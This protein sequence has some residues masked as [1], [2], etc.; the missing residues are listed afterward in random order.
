[1]RLVNFAAHRFSEGRGLTIHIGHEARLWNGDSNVFQWHTQGP[2]FSGTII[3]CALMALERWLYEQIDRGED[4]APWIDRILRESQSLAFA[5]LLFDVGKR[6]PSL[7]ADSLKP[8]LGNWLLVDWDRQVVT[9]HQPRGPEPAGFWGFQPPAMI[10]LGRDWYGMP[11]RRHLLIYI[12]G[13]IVDT[14]IADETQWPFL[15]QLR[16]QWASELDAEADQE[17]P[18]TLLWLIERFNPGNYTFEER[19]GKRVAVA[20]DWPAAMVQ[21]T[22]EDLQRISTGQMVTSFPF[23]CRR[24]LDS[25]QLLSNEQLPQFWDFVQGIENLSP[26]LAHDGEPLQHMEDLLCGA[27][28]VLVVK[29]YDW[30][31]SDAGRI[32]WCRGKLEEIVRRP[33]AP[34]PFDSETAHGDQ[35]WDSFAA[36]AG[37]ALLARDREDLL[38]RRLVANGVLSF[39]YS[40]TS[41]TLIR[42]CQSRERLGDEFD[43]MLSLAVRSSGLRT[44]HAFARRIKP[45]PEVEEVNSGKAPLTE[46]FIDRR[47]PIELPDIH[48]LDT[49]AAADIEAVRARQFPHSERLR[50]SETSSQRPGSEMETLYRDRLSLDTRLLSAT[51]AWLDLGSAQPEERVKWIG[52]VRMFLDLVLSMMPKITDARRQRTDDHPDEFD[53]WVFGRV[54]EAIPCLT[55]AEDHRTL[56]R[57]ILDLGPPSHQWIERF[58]WEWFTLG[59]RAAQNPEQFAAIWGDMIEYALQS[60]AWD[61]ATHRSH[62]LDDAVFW[63]LG[64]GTKINKIGQRT[65]YAAALASMEPLFA[66]AV[67]RWFK[68]SKLVSGFLYWVMQPAAS[69]LLVP[70]II[71][72]APVIP[73][74]DSYDWRNGL[75]DNS[76]AFLRTCW[77]RERERISA[78]TGLERDFRVLLTTA[79][80]RGSHAAIAL[81]DHIVGSAMG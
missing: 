78:D 59:L 81:R 12:G 79:V 4:I 68:S 2:L 11:H 60:P 61:P 26:Q 18:E 66:G 67:R 43:R 50:R 8:L 15:A 76:I 30:I 38:A 58:F 80:S 75:E 36:E 27:I 44:S 10:A 65:E 47:L 74:F 73:P 24:L 39:H 3:H 17:P 72:L 52:F 63:L 51:F 33:P 19:D 34:L 45:G 64:L 62:D 5:G 25:E 28:A 31:A 55:V 22:Q 49:R 40:T 14:L 54:A 71:W 77:D 70:T 32:D 48:E 13:G 9:L 23:Q 7:F 41:R 16:A 53:S 1:M 29:H 6:L 46:E 21:Q 56:W 37:V 69:S 42:A 57:P 20:F 35:R